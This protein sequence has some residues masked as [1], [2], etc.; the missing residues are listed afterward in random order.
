MSSRKDSTVERAF[1]A[2]IYLQY[3]SVEPLLIWIGRGS[4]LVVSALVYLPPHDLFSHSIWITLLYASLKPV[5]FPLCC[6]SEVAAWSR[7]HLKRIVST[8]LARALFA[9]FTLSVM[10]SQS[11]ISF[12]SLPVTV[13][14]FSL[15]HGLHDAH[16]LKLCVCVC[17]T[18]WSACFFSFFFLGHL[19]SA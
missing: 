6:R 5:W 16:H 10:F 11:H 8:C 7:L 17:L 13:S 9:V 4:F 1:T 14:W 15:V 12:V 3:V 18:A 2:F 19:W